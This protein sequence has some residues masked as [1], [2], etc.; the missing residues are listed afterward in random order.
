MVFFFCLISFEGIIFG[1]LVC[2]NVNNY[3]T[4]MKQNINNTFNAIPVFFKNIPGLLLLLLFRNTVTGT[5]GNTVVVCIRL[6]A[7][8]G[9]L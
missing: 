9:G 2:P 4:L 8:S 7:E 6:A 5:T 1:T 3:K